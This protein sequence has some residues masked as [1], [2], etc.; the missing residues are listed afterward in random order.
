MR[1]GG[2]KN[3]GGWDQEMAP[4]VTGNRPTAYKS[5][6]YYTTWSNVAM[7]AIIIY[8]KYNVYFKR[9]HDAIDRSKLP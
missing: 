9:A 6:G 5:P 3:E 2:N 7:Q 4:H 1:G 8:P